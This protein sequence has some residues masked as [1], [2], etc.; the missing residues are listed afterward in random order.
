MV[1]PY[2]GSERESQRGHF[3]HLISDI[4][5]A[6]VD[7][8]NPDGRQ[9]QKY[10]QRIRVGPRRAIILLRRWMTTLLVPL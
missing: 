9:G 1:E 5:G 6:I 8:H 3:Q 2:F 10:R 4:V 7:N